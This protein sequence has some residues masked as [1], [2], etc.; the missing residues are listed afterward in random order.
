MASIKPEILVI[1]VRSSCEIFP[2]NVL[3]VFSI[4]SNEMA[5]LLK[6]SASSETSSLLLTGTAYRNGL[7]KAFGSTAHILDRGDNAFGN[8]INSHQRCSQHPQTGNGNRLDDA[9]YKTVQH[10]TRQADEH[11]AIRIG[12]CACQSYNSGQPLV[13]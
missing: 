13:F 12:I 2:I 11:I 4:F 10:R 8:K 1:G 5:M 7:R 9:F 3:R 6:A